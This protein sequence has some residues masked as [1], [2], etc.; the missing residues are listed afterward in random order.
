ME[1][2]GRCNGVGQME[3]EWCGYWYEGFTLASETTS[4]FDPLHATVD[5]AI[6]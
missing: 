2:M 4:Y 1:P 5:D 3:Y 6:R